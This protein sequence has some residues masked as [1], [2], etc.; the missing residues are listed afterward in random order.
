MMIKLKLSG[1]ILLILTIWT[2]AVLAQAAV[3]GSVSPN[4]KSIVHV[5]Q[6]YP[7]S[8]GLAVL[9]NGNVYCVINEKGEIVIPYNRYEF[10]STDN[11]KGFVNGM[12]QVID[13]KGLAG[14]IDKQGKLIFPFQFTFIN[15]FS[16][17]GIAFAKSYDKKADVNLLY[18]L[19]KD[20]TKILINNRNASGKQ[21]F[22]LDPEGWSEGLC[23][24]YAYKSGP[25]SRGYLNTQGK[26]AIPFQYDGAQPFLNGLAA[27][28]KKDES[29]NIK[30]GFINKNNQLVIPFQFSNEPYPFSDGVS[31][32][33]PL[34]IP[35]FNYGLIDKTGKVIAKFK[36][37]DDSKTWPTHRTKIE[38]FGKFS[39]GIAPWSLFRTEATEKTELNFMDKTGRNFSLDKKINDAGYQV[40][41]SNYT[42]E[43]NKISFYGKD[44]NGETYMGVIDTNG[45]IIIPPVFTYIS[46]FDTVS[47]L[48]YA[49]YENGS[50]V[51]TGY[52]NTQGI[53]VIVTK[54]KTGF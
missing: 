25:S 49:T 39:N 50:N 18:I 13:A 31:T 2:G 4:A 21:I 48:A 34:N 38:G 1:K 52:I 29:G 15:H 43:G 20:G 19:R 23:P 40:I 26:I 12:A 37:E 35:D 8:D 46:N 33:K 30:W 44:K 41:Q 11:F 14:L 22:D 42:I 47:N 9:R 6:L 53:F 32:I 54:E 10:F 45:E 24:I 7:F 17:E 16:K 28:S 5:T 51:I 3:A 36:T 27:V